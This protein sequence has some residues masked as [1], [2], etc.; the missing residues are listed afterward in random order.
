M[1]TFPNITICI[2]CYNNQKVIKEAIDSTLSQNYLDKEILVIDDCSTDMTVEVVESYGTK[3]RLIKN[4]RNL[5]IGKNLVKGLDNARGW[6]VIF[7][8]AD[9]V[10]TGPDVVEDYVKIFD[11][12]PEI[13]II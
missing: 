5:G 3:V 13:G 10:F 12:Y 6:N 8:C 2:P 9:D 4:E 7:L 1:G 11:T